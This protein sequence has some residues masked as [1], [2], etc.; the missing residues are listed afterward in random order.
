MK[1]IGG[2]VLWNWR[3]AT[4]LSSNASASYTRS[5][6]PTTGRKEEIQSFLIGLNR[7]FQPRLSGTLNYRGQRN[8]SNLAGSGY[9]ENAFSAGL[10][11]R[12]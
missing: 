6:F 8:T 12:Y 7:Q 2:S 3:I 5:E 10:S 4:Q 11:L 9:S 1:Q